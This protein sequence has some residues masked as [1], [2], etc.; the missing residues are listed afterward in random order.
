MSTLFWIVG[1]IVCGV[2]TNKINTKKGYDGGFAWGF[3]LGI[4]GIIIVVRSNA[5]VKKAE[6]TIADN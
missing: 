5:P 3:F 2:I 1:A 4:I 6:G